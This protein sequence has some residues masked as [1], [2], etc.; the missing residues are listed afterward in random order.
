MR[1]FSV[2][3]P[4]VLD[5][6]LRVLESCSTSWTDYLLSWRDWSLSLHSSAE[7]PERS[8]AASRGVALTAN[9]AV[10]FNDTSRRNEARSSV[11][12]PW[13]RYR[14]SSHA[15]T[16]QCFPSSIR[17]SPATW[18]SDQFADQ[19]G[20]APLQTTRVR[21]ESATIAS[22][23]SAVSARSAHARSHVRGPRRHG[24]SPQTGDY[25]DSASRSMAVSGK[26]AHNS[27]QPF[28]RH[29]IA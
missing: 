3:F 4:N 17:P 29:R 10:A 24:H 21:A 9:S 19:R 5:G 2:M 1:R 12:P 27:G 6:L 25:L 22:K 16:S 8:P 13:C 15:A 14:R 28:V 26:A 23:H 11:P 18:P 20:G 7:R